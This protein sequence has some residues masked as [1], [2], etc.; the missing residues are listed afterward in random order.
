MHFIFYIRG[1]QNQV[2]LWKTLAQNIFWKWRRTNL[3][4]KKEEITLVQ[5]ALRPSL[6]GAYEY[7]IPEEA[8]AEWLAVI[9]VFKNTG[10]GKD[11]FMN[12][13]KMGFIRKIFG[14][15]KIPKKIFEEAKKISPSVV[16]GNSERGLSNLTNEVIKGVSVY[17][18]GIKKDVK[19]DMDW[20]AQQG[21]GGKYHQEML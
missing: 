4:T 20:D 15:K 2:E 18:V 7:I 13:V 6:F 21:F 19:K 14:A 10:S 17:P 3:K 8:L 12:K 1:I 5:G 11:T 16:I 9:G